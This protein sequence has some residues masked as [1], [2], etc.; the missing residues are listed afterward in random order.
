MTETILLKESSGLP[1]AEC[2]GNSG[3]IMKGFGFDGVDTY[4]V[5]FPGLLFSAD[6]TF[7]CGQCFR[8]KKNDDN[9]WEAV[10]KGRLLRCEGAD[11][12]ISIKCLEGD[13]GDGF[14]AILD[15]YFD[16]GTDYGAL[17]S[18]LSIKDDVMSKACEVSSGIRLLKQDLFETVISFIVS[19]NN[20]IPRIKKC[21]ENICMSYGE[22][23]TDLYYAFPTPEALSSADPA[24]LTKYCRVGY[25]G[26]YIA[27]TAKIFAEGSI[28]LDMLN[29]ESHEDQLKKFL[30]LPG[31]GPKVLNCIMLFS[32]IDRTAFPVDVWVE[33]M[34]DELYGIKLPDRNRLEKYGKEYF[35]ENAGLAQQYL[36]YYI[37]NIHG[38]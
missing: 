11:D 9:S 12:V 25:R 24:D 6:K 28:S 36:F 33:R 34:M 31:V 35:G 23:I 19:A 1:G 32:G 21:I 38:K 15:D 2:S 16:I 14:S 30:S 10:V 5:S 37:R 13:C 26:P 7:D 29:A 27:E 8:W 4:T 22:K 20:N 17:T 3:K 18:E